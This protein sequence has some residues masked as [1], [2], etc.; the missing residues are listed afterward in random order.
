MLEQFE[1]L[2]EAQIRVKYALLSDEEKGQFREHLLPLMNMLAK[3]M[4]AAQVDEKVMNEQ[5]IIAEMKG[6]ENGLTI[7]E[8]K[9]YIK[10]LPEYDSDNEND[11]Y[12]VWI[13]H[14]DGKSS[15]VSEIYPLNLKENGS[16]IILE[17]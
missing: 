8:L 3:T 11:P 7:A 17:C 16:D 2:T 14:K 9:K 4:M 12:E 15:I 13:K 5:K 6:F 10:D 1:Y